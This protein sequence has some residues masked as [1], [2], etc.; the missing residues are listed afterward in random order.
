M[1]QR[2]DNILDAAK[3]SFALFGYKGTT[4]DQIAKIAS[5]GKGTLYLYFETKEDLLNEIVKSLIAEMRKLADASISKGGTIMEKLH[6]ATYSILVYRKEH[7]LL[8]KL[9]QEV[10]QFGTPAAQHALREIEEGVIGY[11]K[12]HLE[13]AVANGSIKPCDPEITAFV[14]VRMY[15]VLLVDWERKHPPLT[16]EQISDLIQ[17][18]MMDGIAL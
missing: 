11:I 12:Q 14:L 9:S 3:K 7:E 17:L 8:L 13:I 18:Y 4:V 16:N 10:A 6:S 15:L 1:D 5:V 2:R